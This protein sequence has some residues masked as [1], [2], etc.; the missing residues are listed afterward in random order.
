LPGLERRDQFVV[1]VA[2]STAGR[3]VWKRTTFTMIDGGQAGHDVAQAA[4]RQDEGDRRR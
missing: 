3:R 2:G 1:T 4:R